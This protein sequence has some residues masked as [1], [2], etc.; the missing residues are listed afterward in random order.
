M[1]VTEMSKDVG[2]RG[3]LASTAELGSQ[4]H[5]LPSEVPAGASSLIV[6]GAEEV[7]KLNSSGLVVGWVITVSFLT[8]ESCRELVVS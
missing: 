7:C 8:Q 5:H 1:P 3:T 4:G 2:R 6:V